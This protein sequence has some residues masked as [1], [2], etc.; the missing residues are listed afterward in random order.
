MGLV[1]E[2]R[3]RS[4]FEW[5]AHD[6]WQTSCWNTHR[7]CLRKITHMK[8]CFPPQGKLQL[9]TLPETFEWLLVIPTV[10]YQILSRQALNGS[11]P[12]HFPG[13]SALAP[14][15]W[16][17]ALK[18]AHFCCHSLCKH[19]PPHEYPG[20]LLFVLYSI[21]QVCIMARLSIS[22]LILNIVTSSVM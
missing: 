7:T 21:A 10:Q 16:L 2:P 20:G 6:L 22:F 13:D 14:A 18:C 19:C 12:A 1:T 5:A 9:W 15:S 4:E 11:C 8:S 17:T 3:C